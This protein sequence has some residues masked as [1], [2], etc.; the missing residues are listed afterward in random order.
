MKKQINPTIKAHLIR[1]AFYVLLLLAVCVIPFALAQRN[2]TGRAATKPNVAAN[3]KHAN[4][5]P[6]QLSNGAAVSAPKAPAK[7][8][9]KKTKVKTAPS[10]RFSNA[11]GRVPQSAALHKRPAAPTG[12]ACAYQFTS[13][14]DAIVPGD[15]DIGNHADDGDTFVA[16][17]FTFQLYDQTFN[18]VNVSSNGRLDFVCVN[19]PGGFQSACLPPPDN[20][21]PFDYTIFPV[22]TDYRTDIVGEGCASFASGCG[23]FTSISGSAP[24][25]IFNIE[26]R[27]VY[28]ADHNQTANFE[29]R[30][31]ESDPDLRFDFIYGT[32]NPGSDQLYVSGVEQNSSNFTQDFCDAGPPAAGSR[33][34]TCTGVVPSPTPTPTCPPGNPNGAA[35]PWTAG[36][37]Y[38]TTIVRY[39]FVQTATHFYVFGGVDN[40]ATTNAVNRMDLATGTWEPRAPMPFQGEAPT[41]SLM[42]DTGIVYCT[43]GLDSNSFASY[44]IATDTWTPLAPD[45]FAPDHY[46]SASGAFNGKV[47]VAGGFDP[48]AAV[49]VYDVASDTWSSGTAAPTTFFLA[50]Y[51]QIGQFLYVVGGFDPSVINNATTWRLDMSSAPGVWEVGPAFTP[52]RADFGLA[53]DPGTNKLYALG[54]DLPNDGNFFNSSNLVDELDLSGW[55]G[56]TWNPSPPDLPLPNRQANQAGFYGNG[57]IWS[58]GG[59]DGA[60]FQFL[61]EVWHRNNS[62]GG[63]CTPTPS[64]TPSPSGTPGSCPPTITQSTTQSIV[65]GN[66]VACNNGFGTTE[67]HY[68]RAFNMNTFTGGLEYDVTSVEFGIELAA[69]GGGTGQPLT[70]NLYANHGSPFPGGD[71]Q[72]NLI[73]TSGE[74]NI[75]DQIDSIFNVPL[76]ATVAA[77]TLE[78]VMEVTTPDGTVVGNL[79]FIGSN[80]DPET[81]TSY[82]SAADCGVPDPTPVGDI[83]FPGMHIV[84][85]VN[86]SCPAGGSPT[87]TP[88]PSVTPSVSPT[89]TATATPTA[90]TPPVSPT[91]SATRPPPTPR[92]RPTPY[93]R[94]TP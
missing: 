76:I 40:G 68:W 19:E 17:P 59:L 18:G 75:P 22:W 60:T 37:A 39:G 7:A 86:G 52:Q 43:D 41:C 56:G 63:G 26:W 89:P 12:V 9:A 1:G 85:N 42:E 2:T 80:P 21:C 74:I 35:G 73:G 62:G 8:S 67:N 61:N 57:D 14:G 4:R 88:T 82:L 84:L 65:D 93:P 66:S 54:G 29:A 3:T 45:P 34:Y 78:L 48:G 51:H 92:P 64:P 49:D 23:V 87:P 15:T 83:G 50:G 58:V 10:T 69:S 32:V 53:Y 77:G 20:Q 38:P 13:G 5:A 16:L 28:F 72:S 55:P 30:I 11:L 25:R 36:N 91:P 46:G 47:F 71:W 70:V 81:G 90:T 79:F 24:N 33:S 31:Y 6:G 44:D 27:A 94:P